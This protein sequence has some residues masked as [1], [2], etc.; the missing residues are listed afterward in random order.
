MDTLV[1]TEAEAR[2]LMERYWG[3][4]REQ[5]SLRDV[6]DWTEITT[7]YLDR[8]NDHLQVYVRP[9]SDGWL[10]TDDGY[11]ID[12][13]AQSGCQ[14]DSP[15]GRRML[16]SATAGFGVRVEGGALVVNA[17]AAD[18]P[19]HKHNLV[20]AMLSVGGLFHAMESDASPSAPQITATVVD[21]ASG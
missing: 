9:G 1:H 13:L 18:F 10:L 7:P 21:V 15:R 3:W 5:T 19:R 17:S 8:H 11:V 6:G 16:E 12:D 20:Q 4:L 14:V 2:D